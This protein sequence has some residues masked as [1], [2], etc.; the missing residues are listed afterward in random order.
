MIILTDL[1][2]V[3]IRGISG[4]EKIIRDRYGKRVAKEFIQRRTNINPIFCELMRGHISEDVYWYVFLQ[5]N[6]WPFGSNELKEIFSLNLMKKIPG[7]LD[8]YRR[9]I[10]YPDSTG[11]MAA[12]IDGRPD[13]WLVSDHIFERE[14]EL[15][16]LHP[17]VFE[18]VSNQ[19]WSFDY[20]ALKG[21]PG[22]FRRILSCYDLLPE[23][24]VFVDDYQPNIAAASTEGIT[25]IKFKDAEQ[26]ETELV[27]LGFLFADT[28]EEANDLNGC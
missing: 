16:Y 17:D 27:R 23:E 15:E 11:M 24:V 21:D 2:E 22:F 26:L 19:I 28:V 5:N 3:L 7:T 14:V 18:L 20:S 1:S 6:N 10:S 12:Q 4:T 8:V 13:F 9:I 25:A